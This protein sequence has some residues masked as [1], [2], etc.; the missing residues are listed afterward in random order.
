MRFCV[1]RL[2]SLNRKITMNWVCPTKET[3]RIIE[4]RNAAAKAKLKAKKREVDELCAEV[5]DLVKDV[6]DGSHHI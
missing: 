2:K 4:A 3:L 6:A 5:T 1:I